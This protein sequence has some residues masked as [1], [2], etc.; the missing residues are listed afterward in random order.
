MSDNDKPF[1]LPF[2]KKEK[3]NKDTYTFYFERT[4]D[5]RPF[6]AGQYYE[7]KLPHKN[8]DDRGDSRVFTISSSPNDKEYISITTR[9]IQSTFKLALANLKEGDVIHFDGPWDDLNFDENEKLPYVFLAG[10]IG[11][12]PYHSII[13][14][15]IEK[16]L[17]NKMT[18]FVS[19]KIRED[20]V[21]HEFFENAQKTLP[22][23]RYIPTL[24]GEESDNWKYE[25]GRID[26]DMIKRY[27]SGILDIK[28]FVAGPPPMVVALKKMILDMNVPKE[29]VVSED[30]EGYVNDKF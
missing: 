24:T 17:K 2:V 6:V 27:M 19:W 7:I 5:A 29:N 26:A 11:V 16:G 4:K 28:C 10:G 12:T 21:F 18:L 13:K 20:M 15:S 25:T 1:F 9:I 30:F 14:Y 23:F 3:L 22:N 8:M